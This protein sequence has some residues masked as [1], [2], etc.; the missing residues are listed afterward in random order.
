[1]RSIFN[2]YG[3]LL[4]IA[5]VIILFDQW[6]KAWV[7]NNIPLGEVLAPIPALKD[8]AR[9]VHWNN[10]GAA[11]G[12]FQG[13]SIIFT[14]LAIVVSV[15][16]IYYYPRI[17]RTEWPLRLALGLQLGGAIGNLIDRLSFGGYVT[18]FISLGNFAVFNM[19]DASISVGV[20]VLVIGVWITDHQ[21]PLDSDQER[22]EEDDSQMNDQPAGES[23]DEANIQRKSLSK[24]YW[25]D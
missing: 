16:I 23:D 13:L 14:V 3:A 11:F 19:A 6:T 21:Q 22:L 20:A 5:G 8:Y 1:L 7:R 15:G 10:T 18:D 2:K 25:G 4:T 12:M 9:L 24:E 17:P